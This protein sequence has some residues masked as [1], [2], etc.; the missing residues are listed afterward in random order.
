M[1]LCDPGEAL[2]QVW[3]IL[4]VLEGSPAEVSQVAV[5][6][7]LRISKCVSTSTVQSA[8]TLVHVA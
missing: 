1:R 8:G 6:R 2:G 3:H 5:S 7:S 4:E